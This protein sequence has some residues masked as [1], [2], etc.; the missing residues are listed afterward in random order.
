MEYLVP[1]GVTLSVLGLAGLLYCIGA[2][3][4]AKRKGLTD[5][6][7]RARLKG[8]VAWNMGALLLSTLGLM[9]VIMGLFLT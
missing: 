4:S 7:L 9:A 5:E 1:I 8:L 3:F 6:A 2:A